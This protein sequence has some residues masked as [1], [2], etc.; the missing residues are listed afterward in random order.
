MGIQLIL[1]IIPTIVSI[2]LGIFW[3]FVILPKQIG[4]DSEDVEG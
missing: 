1:W 4:E 2:L 3:A